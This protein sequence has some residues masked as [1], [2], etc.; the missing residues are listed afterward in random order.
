MEHELSAKQKAL[1]QQL[2]ET[3]REKLVKYAD[4]MLK[5]HADAVLVTPSFFLQN[6]KDGEYRKALA[7]A[8]L[9]LVSTEPISPRTASL[10]RN[11][12]GDALLCGYG[13]SEIGGC[14]M[15]HD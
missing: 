9:V 2:Y 8:K 14:I 7:S 13:C 5:N 10:L 1:L 15:Y 3:Y 6:Y 11:V 12:V 4:V